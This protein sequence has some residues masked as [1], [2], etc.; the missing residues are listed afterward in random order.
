MTD[1]ARQRREPHLVDLE[2]PEF[3]GDRPVGTGGG[4]QGG[5][6]PAGH[7]RAGAVVHEGHTRARED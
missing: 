1:L 5:G 3:A 7:V 6:N 4:K 2:Q